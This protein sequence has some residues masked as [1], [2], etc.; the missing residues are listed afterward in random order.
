M[1]KVLLLVCCAFALCGCAERR[2]SSWN[3]GDALT[4][5]R[6]LAAAVSSETW[7]EGFSLP[8]ESRSPALLICTL[9][10]RSE[11]HVALSELEE[12][13]ARELLLSGKVRLIRP[14]KD[15]PTFVNG[16]SAL[17]D[18]F[19]WES[20]GADALLRGWLEVVPDR[21]LLVFRLTLEIL[22]TAGGT[23]LLRVAK[24]TSKPL[25]TK[26]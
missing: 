22:D 7:L 18:S 13:L 24:S 9:E 2:L 3:D 5:A 4:L 14:R 12:E 19:S 15:S 11:Y 6:E 16:G 1:K 10:N 21:S 20:S 8:D 17:L 25:W 26:L 23:T